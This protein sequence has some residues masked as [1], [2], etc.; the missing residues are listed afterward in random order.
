[1][2]YAKS[3][4][5]WR[6]ESPQGEKGSSVELFPQVYN[7]AI[8]ACGSGR[9]ETALAVL[10][11]TRGQHDLPEPAGNSIWGKPCGVGEGG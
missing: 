1:M 4:K 11:R 2:S 9:W 6:K 7:A 8:G 3:W 5:A 10:E